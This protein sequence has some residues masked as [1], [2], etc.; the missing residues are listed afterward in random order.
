MKPLVSVVLLMGV[1][2]LVA[3][4]A[5]S[6]PPTAKHYAGTLIVTGLGPGEIDV[7]PACLSFKKGE[8]C[9]ELGDCGTWEFVTKEGHR[10]EW[11][12]KLDFEQE[13]VLIRTD[14]RGITERVGTGS[15]IAA[16]LIVEVAG[17]VVNGAFAGVQ[18]TR[19][20]CLEF[21]SSDD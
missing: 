9:T 11:V 1:V 15:A 12:G 8:M 3:A 21:G 6:T 4:P 7:A 16:T 17:T 13:G 10:N 20:D 18:V 2:A 5:L 14:V 19:R